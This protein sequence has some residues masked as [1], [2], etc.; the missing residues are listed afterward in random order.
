MGRCEL[1]DKINRSRQAIGNYAFVTQIEALTGYNMGRRSREI[2]S[3]W[4]K[5]KI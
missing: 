5:K 1:N 4:R 2:L 3:G